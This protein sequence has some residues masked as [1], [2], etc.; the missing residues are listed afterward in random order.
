M[1]D[2]AVGRGRLAFSVFFSLERGEK[3][4]LSCTVACTRFPPHFGREGREIEASTG[5]C[6]LGA[7]Q[8]YRPTIILFINFFFCWLC[9]WFFVACICTVMYC[10]MHRATKLGR[11]ICGLHAVIGYDVPPP[12][13]HL[14]TPALATRATA[15]FRFTTD[16]GRICKKPNGNSVQAM[17]MTIL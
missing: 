5:W 6:A 14:R 2:V 16:P 4:S 13:P 10:K 1:F 7:S 12:T 8:G 17:F 9:L 11:R 15:I 3:G